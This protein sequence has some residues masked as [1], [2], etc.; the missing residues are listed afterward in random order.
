MLLSSAI[1]A[2]TY[3]TPN[4]FS[5]HY[6][7]HSSPEKPGL[8]NLRS[9]STLHP[10]SLPPEPPKDAL[11]PPSAAAVAAAIRRASPTS[12]VEFSE[13]L[14]KLG[15]SGMIQPSPD[16]QRLCIEQLELFR[17]VVQHDAVLSV[18]VRPAGSFVMDQ[19]E[20]RRV[21]FY[22]GN[23]ISENADCV[24]L[25]ANFAIPAGL[26]SAEAALSKL[27]VEYVPEYQTL[28][29][30]MVRQ[31]F[32]VGFLVAELPSMRLE[33]STNAQQAQGDMP[34]DLSPSFNEKFRGVQTS[35][36]DLMN[37]CHCLTTEETTRA[38][39]I[40]RSLAMAYVMDQKAML[41]QQSSWQNNF[42]MGH[43]VEQIRGCLSSIRAL[44]K[45]LSIQVKR[46][47]V[48]HDIVE[49]ILMQGDNMNDALQQLQDVVFLTKANVLWHN[50]ETSRRMHDSVDIASESTRSLLSNKESREIQD[51][52]SRKIDPSIPFVSGKDIELP[53]PPLL[54][55]PLQLHNV[56]PCE[57][58]YVL[59]DLVGAARPLANLQQRSLELNEL[60]HELQVAVEESGLRQALSNLIEGALLRTNV[61]GK[62]EVFAARAPAGG[63]LVI[64]DDDGP[65]MHYM[66][67]MHSLTPFGADL[68]SDGTVQDNMTW[69]FIAGLTVA[70]EILESYGCVIRVISPC[71][72]DAALHAGG[73]RIEVWLPTLQSEF[74][75]AQEA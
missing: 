63:A 32:V 14:E 5:H 22:P 36:G 54:L 7:S 27:Q 21:T 34:F 68:F 74:D 55:A 26:R 11:S 72:P 58:S 43:L 60:S 15:K 39:M 73:T 20:L 35:K 19:L 56:G 65:D 16:F 42:Q 45:M 29:L 17:A 6:H 48:A 44:S 52:R 61:G 69:N 53:M 71:R 1:P 13:R 9:H 4:L 25:V 41:L 23:D 31:P 18:F 59:R 30:P 66:T 70:R 33:T 28:V 38:I 10:V 46:S 12:P 49:D 51:Y 57:V 62:V 3:R 2:H 50:E 47:E 8:R 40:S 24:I 75:S 67:Q 37:S 64:I